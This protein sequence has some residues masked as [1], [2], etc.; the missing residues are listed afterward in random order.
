[1]AELYTS[2]YA[3]WKA[4]T[5]ALAEKHGLINL[6]VTTSNSVPDWFIDE[7]LTHH[8]VHLSN[9]K[10]L[11]PAWGNV[12]LHKKGMITDE[13]FKA[14]Y[15]SKLDGKREVILFFVKSLMGN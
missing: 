7:A 2:N 14:R 12:D 3:S 5:K 15:F 11:I 4:D 10:I 8:K 1:M 9:M 13:Q 6:L